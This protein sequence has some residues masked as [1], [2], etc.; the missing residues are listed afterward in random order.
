VKKNKISTSDLF[1]TLGT[2]GAP[3]VSWDPET[4]NAVTVASEEET[5]LLRLMGAGGA[6]EIESTFGTSHNVLLGYLR[7]KEWAKMESLLHKVYLTSSDLTSLVSLVEEMA[8]MKAVHDMSAWQIFSRLLKHVAKLISN[9]NP[10]RYKKERASFNRI[11][12][13]FL[14][15]GKHE[16]AVAIASAMNDVTLNEFLY[17]FMMQNQEARLANICWSNI[18]NANTPVQ[19]MVPSRPK[20][21]FAPSTLRAL[22]LQKVG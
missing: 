14:S 20:L 15:E 8:K 21:L 2:N 7:S 6:G 12:L 3:T 18:K 1:D 17:Q 22:S 16:A 11:A 19:N 4:R 13:D 10:N 9:A 5:V